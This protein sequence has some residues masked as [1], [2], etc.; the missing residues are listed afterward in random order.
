MRWPDHDCLNHPPCPTCV[1]YENL[2]TL[3]VAARRVVEH[4]QGSIV[5][6]KEA[7]DAL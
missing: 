1:F 7:L 4:R 6:L 3:I 5:E 2:N